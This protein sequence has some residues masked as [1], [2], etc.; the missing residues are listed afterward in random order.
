MWGF[1]RRLNEVRV[2]H[3]LEPGDLDEL[4][5]A[6]VERL[7][8]DRTRPLDTPINRLRAAAHHGCGYLDAIC[9]SP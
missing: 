3:Q 2:V 9:G 6:V 7:W 1:M 5:G 8:S 4:I